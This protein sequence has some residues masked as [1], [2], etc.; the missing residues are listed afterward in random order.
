M[1]PFLGALLGAVEQEVVGVDDGRVSTASA[2]AS[3]RSSGR[4]EQRARA[5][6]AI[7][8]QEN[9]STW[10]NEYAS[11]G[12]TGRRGA[13]ARPRGRSPGTLPRAGGLDEFAQRGPGCVPARRQTRRANSLPSKARRDVLGRY[14]SSRTIKAALRRGFRPGKSRTARRVGSNSSRRPA[15]RLL[16]QIEALLLLVH[17]NEAIANRERRPGSHPRRGLFDLGG[18]WLRAHVGLILRAAAKP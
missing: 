16:A 17:S 2:W 13:T 14:V 18:H 9:S 3:S 12:S 5:A 4:S 11:P 15:R 6:A 7:R 1:M 8:R 10:W